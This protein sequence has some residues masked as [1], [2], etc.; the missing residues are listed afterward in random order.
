MAAPVTLA[1]LIE[2]GA[3]EGGTP[4]GHLRGAMQPGGARLM[5]TMAKGGRADTTAVCTCLP[6]ARAWTLQ[7]DLPD[8]TLTCRCSGEA[9]AVE[10]AQFL[11]DRL[12]TIGW[13]IRRTP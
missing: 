9:A 10:R 7:V 12:R 11:A 8:G 13:V 5:W 2:A 3:L 4:G 6:G 1:R